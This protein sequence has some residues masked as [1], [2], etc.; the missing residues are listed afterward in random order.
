[1]SVAGRSISWERFRRAIKAGNR[2]A[3]LLP[4][5]STLGA[6]VYLRAP[7][8]PD[9]DHR[10]LWEI[11]AVPSPT[12]YHRCPKEDSIGVFRGK[13]FRVRGYNQ[14]FKTARRMR[15]RY[16][17]ESRVIFDMKKVLAHIPDALSAWRGTEP[18]KKRVREAN[19]T[20]I[21]RK[22][23]EL[24]KRSKPIEGN[25]NPIGAAR[26]GSAIYS[27]GGVA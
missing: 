8:H 20:E 3:V 17:G 15:I 26:Q 19:Q 23:T 25:G 1:M 14:F 24:H 11:M 2:D 6:M 5:R 27:F 10:G 4:S 12:F 9:S 18:M 7:K 22:G 16:E 21:E 13:K